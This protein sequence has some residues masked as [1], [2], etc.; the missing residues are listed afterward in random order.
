MYALMLKNLACLCPMS[1]I[2]DLQVPMNFCWVL[3]DP[4]PDTHLKWEE[5]GQPG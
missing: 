2:S 1:F 3:Q 5:T 4:N